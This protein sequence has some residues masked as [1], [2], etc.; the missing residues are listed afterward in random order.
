[1]RQLYLLDD[2]DPFAMPLAQ[3]VAADATQAGITVVGQDHLSITS[4]AVFTGEGE[5]IVEAGA[6]AVF[7]SGAGSEAAASLWRQLHETD[8]RLMLLGSSAVVDEAFASQIGAAGPQAYATTPVLPTWMYPAAAQRVLADYRRRFAGEAEA[9]VL[10]GYEAMSL[11]L[12]AIRA[13]GARGNDRQLIAQTVL[14]SRRR[15]S[16]LGRYSIQADGDTTL[17][18]FAVDRVNG[19]RFVFAKAIRVGR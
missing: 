17:S 3:L 11:V 13:A 7:Y 14:A 5:K 2:G 18:T 19:G 9:Y 12:Q 4:G 6:Q 15:N 8:P 16:V 10:Y 1:V